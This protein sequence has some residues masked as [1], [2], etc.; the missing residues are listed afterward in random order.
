MSTTEEKVVWITWE[1]QRRTSVLSEEI[2]ASLYVLSDSS[3]SYKYRFVR[4]L[5]LSLK[6]LSVVLRKRPHILIVQNPSIV[7]AFVACI[8]RFIFKYYLIIDRHSNFKFHKN[9]GFVWY[10]FHK[11]SEFTIKHADLTIVTNSYLA[12]FVQ[13]IGGDSFVLPDKIPT[14][15]LARPLNLSTKK[16]IVYVCSF[17]DD[18]PVAEVIEAVNNIKGVMVYITGDYNN[19]KGIFLK[20]KYKYINNV[21]FTGFLDE[22]SYQSFLCSAHVIL[23][24][25]KQEYTLTCGAY[26]AVSLYKPMV[27]S[28]TKTIRNYFYKGAKYCDP[29]AV[30][31]AF[32]INEAIISIENLFYEVT[33]MKLELQNRWDRDFS[34]LLRKIACETGT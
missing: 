9:E 17:N 18:E 12:D 30:S 2:G 22:D 29:N 15:T 10:I 26:E 31:I 19:A 20:E 11:L 24:L 16:N 33:C 8:Y 28:N 32:A 5:F 13:K 3:R 34:R 27:L 6:T 25:T 21:V 14:L 1:R 7:L 23:V 4:Y